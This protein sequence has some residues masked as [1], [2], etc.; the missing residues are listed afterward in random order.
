MPCNAGRGI[1]VPHERCAASLRSSGMSG[2]TMFQFACAVLKPQIFEKAVRSLL[3]WTRQSE[4]RQRQP[5]ARQASRSG[6][7]EE[8]E[9]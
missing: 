9:P 2:I 4:G 7:S 5:L 3:A 6:A 8:K 1:A